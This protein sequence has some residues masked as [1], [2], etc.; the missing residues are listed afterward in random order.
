MFQVSMV[1]VITCAIFVGDAEP[2]EDATIFYPLPLNGDI[3]A[4]NMLIF[5]LVEQL[6]DTMEHAPV[7]V[8]FLRVPPL[9]A[10]AAAVAR[11]GAAASAMAMIVQAGRLVEVIVHGAVV[12]VPGNAEDVVFNLQ[13]R[14]VEQLHRRRPPRRRRQTL[15]D[16]PPHQRVF[17]LVQSCR[18]YPLM[19]IRSKQNKL[20]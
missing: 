11:R 2:E 5:M 10:G 12:F 1:R 16:E 18:L 13:K 20:N 4:S 6:V 7:I 19:T 14:V 8:V 17:H 9:V 15:L 3:D